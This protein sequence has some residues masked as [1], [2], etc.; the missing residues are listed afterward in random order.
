MNTVLRER[1]FSGHLLQLVQGDISAERVDAIVNAANS[2]L[3]HGGGVA[4]ILSRRGGPEIQ[5]ESNQWLREHGPVSHG[6]PA[7]TG[8]GQ[9]PCRYV[10]HAVGP[11]WGAGN[12][13]AKLTDAVRGALIAA[14]NLELAS[15]SLPAI[16]TGIFGFPKELAAQI[17]FS[18]IEA[19]FASQADSPLKQVRLVLFDQATLDVFLAK[20]DEVFSN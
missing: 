10:I 12:E 14:S 8:A 13:N 18:T 19:F 3:Q 20:W 1:N 17:I 4:G 2:G 15:L 6:E 11:I 7:V 16:S 5:R 9:L